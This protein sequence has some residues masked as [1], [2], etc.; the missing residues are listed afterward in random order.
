MA[1]NNRK[2]PPKDSRVDSQP[3]SKEQLNSPKQEIPVTTDS[4]IA[5][6][7]GST[8]QAESKKSVEL[9][10]STPKFNLPGFLKE[11]NVE[12]SKVA[13]PSRQQLISESLAVLLMVI[14]AAVLVYL[15]D[16]LFG[17]AASQVF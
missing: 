8:I 1:K 16:S 2:N 9:K 11:V 5:K 3:T 4:N 15:V 7:P 12:L 14:V 10:D 13:W 17:W 6:S